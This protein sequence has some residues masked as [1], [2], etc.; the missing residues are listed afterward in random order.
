MP[1]SEKGF[2]CVPKPAA[3]MQLGQLECKKKKDLSLNSY[4][5]LSKENKVGALGRNVKF[6]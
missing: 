2:L 6:Q 4:Q 5:L 3:Y 1:T